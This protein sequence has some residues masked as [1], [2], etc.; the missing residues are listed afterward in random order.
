MADET[1]FSNARVVTRDAVFTGTVAV[2]Q[3]RITA[4]DSGKSALPGTVDIEG[5]LL[6]P[7]LIELHTDNLE[8]H[9]APRPGVWWPGLAAMVSHDGQIAAAGITTVFDA[10]TLGDRY[11]AIDQ[12]TALDEML[13]AIAQSSGENLLRCDHRVHLRCEVTHPD[14]VDLLDPLVEDPRV[15]LVSLMDHTPGDRQFAD[16]DRYKEL[17]QLSRHLSED[18]VD[19]HLADLRADQERYGQQGRS[20]IVALAQARG[21]VLASHDDSC[22]AHVEQARHEAVAIAEFP[23]SLEAANAAREHGL[24]ILMGAPNLVRGGS[25]SG[26]IAAGEL[27]RARLLDILSSDYY[28]ASLLNGAFL[29]SGETYGFSL[30]DAVATVTANPA[31]AAGLDDRGEIAVGKAADLVRVHDAPALP[32]IRGVWRGGHRVA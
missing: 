26:N 27:A 11:R 8:K 7:G 28:P 23:T 13:S 30:P 17:Y 9:V 6:I 31:A 12:A 2:S 1:V 19:T 10:L 22:R 32:V 29:L 5:D 21:L 3:G 25:H 15:G 14:V 16:I 20:A 18:E 24:K 4:L